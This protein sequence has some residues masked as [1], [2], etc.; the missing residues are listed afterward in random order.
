MIE[1]LK[2]AGLTE[3]EAKA[4]LAL[5]TYGVQTGR[6]VAANSGVPPTRVFDTLKSLVDKGLA[7]LIREKPMLFK[8]IRAEVGLKTLFER[9]KERIETIE[10]ETLDALKKIKEKPKVKPMIHEKLEVVLGFTQM[11]AEVVNMFSKAKKE[12]LVFSVGEE[13]PYSVKLTS[14]KLISK[15]VVAKLIVTKCD[16]ENKHILQ[17]RKKEGWLLRHYPGVGDFTFFFSSPQRGG[18]SPGGRPPKKIPFN[19]KL[20]WR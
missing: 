12:I 6:E 17:E 20:G 10:K 13:I 11:F 5:L 3:Y 9:Q 15:G 2:R 1:K 7:S 4:Y 8:A 14:R 19:P 16:E 18:N